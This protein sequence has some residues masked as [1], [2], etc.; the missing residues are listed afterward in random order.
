MMR[1]NSIQLFISSA[2]MMSGLFIPIIAHEFSA[3]GTEIGMIGAVYGATLFISTYIFSRA[4][5]SY[6]P[7]TILCAGFAGSAFTFFVQIFA[8]DPLS[9]GVI[10]A[11][12]GFSVGIYPAVLILYVYNLKRSI[13]KF[14]SFMPLGWALGNV[15]AGIIAVY[16]QIFALSSLLFALS[17]IITLS[18]PDAEMQVKKKTDYL[19]L[20]ILRKNWD[21]YFSFFLRQSGANNV[22]IIFPLYLTSLGADKLWIGIIYMLNP[23]L[24]FLIMRRLDRYSSVLLVNA[25]YLLS[26]AAFLSFIPLT[27]YYQAVVG[28][29][30]IAFSFS[31][32]YVGS[33]RMLIETN[34]DKGAAAGLLNSAIALSTITGSLIGGTVLENF[35][36][37]AVMATAA[38]FAVVGYAIINIS[39]RS[40]KSS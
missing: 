26:A 16:W 21:V 11:L 28:M 25:G 32:L 14:S 18:L 31:S 1:L 37:Y 30:I 29:T 35:G 6:P 2:V 36:Y 20:D 7:K 12:A 4:A 3:T 17:F 22:W 10:R 24:Q 39:G 38:V 33:V 40:R 5:G 34:E 27:V 9:L 15:L 13:G 8:Y 19:S 23:A